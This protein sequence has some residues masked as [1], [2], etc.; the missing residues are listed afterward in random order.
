MQEQF[1]LRQSLNSLLVKLFNWSLSTQFYFGSE[2]VEIL[3]SLS[4]IAGLIS[5]ASS[6][7]L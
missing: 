6:R 2:F 1:T 5:D 7:M 3:Y 4:F